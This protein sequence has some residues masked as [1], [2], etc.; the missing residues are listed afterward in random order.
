[1]KHKATDKDHVRVCHER[2]IQKSH[3]DLKSEPSEEW[4]STQCLTC[5][6]FIP[7][8]GAFSEDWGVCSNLRSPRDGLATFEHDGCEAHEE[9]EELFQFDKSP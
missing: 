2:W 4:L 3:R 8:A 6:Y 5:A 7:L 1:V 9:A